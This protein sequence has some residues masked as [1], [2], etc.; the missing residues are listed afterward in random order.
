M[1]LSLNE[2]ENAKNS[3]EINASSSPVKA[4]VI[5]TDEELVIARHT[6]GLLN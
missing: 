6:F 4:W 3:F 2:A 5:P 1:G